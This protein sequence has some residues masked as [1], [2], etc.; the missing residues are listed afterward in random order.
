MAMLQQEMHLPVSYTDRHQV[1]II[2]PVEETFTWRFF[3]LAAQEWHQVISVEMNFECLIAYFISFLNFFHEVWLTSSSSESW[4]HIL[5]RTNISDHA[6]GFNNAWPSH[7]AWYSP[8]S[9]PICIFFTAERCSS[10][11]RP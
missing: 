3:F 6:T 2:T 11:V 7:H 4:D 9:F 10:T 1:S 8:S 5:Q